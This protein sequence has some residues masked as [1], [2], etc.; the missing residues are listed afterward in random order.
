MARRRYVVTYD[1]ADDKRRDRVFRVL[2]DNG[3]HLQYSVFMCELNDRE[4]VAL[5]ASLSS[6]LHQREDQVLVIDLGLAEHEAETKVESI[7]RAFSAPTRVV[8]V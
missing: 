1:V 8:V 4:L 7:G 5:R 6:L 3:E 2:G